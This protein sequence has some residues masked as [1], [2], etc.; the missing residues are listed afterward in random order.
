MA[1]ADKLYPNCDA[2]VWLRSCEQEVTE[3]LDGEITGELPEWLRGTLLRNG[4]GSLKVG[5]MR[6][7]HL[8]DSSA[9]LHRFAIHEGSVTYQ[10][11]FL[12]SSTYKRNQAAQRIVVS[13]FGTKAVPDPCH[14]IF[15]RVASVFKP[16]ETISDNAMISLYPFGDEIYAFT[17]GPVIHRI[18]PVTL[19][20]MERKNMMDS[21]ALVNHTS[22]PHVMSNGDVYNVGMSVVKGRVKHV[23]VKFPFTEK[24]DMFARARVVGSLR[25]RWPLHPAY[26]HTF[27]ITEKYFVIVEQPL[28]VSLYG[29]LRSQVAGAPLADSLHW[30]PDQDCLETRMNEDVSI[31]FSVQYQSI[32]S[33]R[34][35]LLNHRLVAHGVARA[36]DVYN[37]GMSVVK[38]RVKHVVV[39]FPFTEKGDMFARARVVGSL[40]PRWPL[41]P[42]YMHTFGITEKYFVIVEQPLAVSLYGALRSQVAGAPLADSLHWY[43]DQDTHIVLISRSTG[44]EER[45]Y[46]TEPLF[47]LHIINAFERDGTLVLDLCAYKDA[48]AIDAM[49]VQAIETHIV[50]ISRSTGKEERRYCTEPLFFLHIIN[51]FERDGTLVLDLCAYKDAKAIDAMYVQAIENMQSN[52]DYAEWF[53]GRPQRLELPLDA[54]TPARVAARPLAALGCETPRIHYDAFNGRPYRYFYAISS[55]VDAEYPG[56]VIKV[57]TW[58]GATLTWS[59]ADCYP[60]EPVFVPAPDAKSEDDGVLLSALVYG[61]DARRVAL[62][63]LCARSLRRRALA[64]F[65]T[66]SP[67]PKCLHGWFLRVK[68]NRPV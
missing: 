33:F 38:G 45:R 28:A 47:F 10:C 8:F 19:D 16:D 34:A 62:L 30:Y 26:M 13:E 22:H 65:R 5:D 27:G 2:S 32:P 60:S 57:D 6:F 25:P 56:A 17:E 3:P 64:A 66:P 59:S 1:A 61:R 35:R 49:Y 21:V 54:T 40:R 7:K 41:H 51:A 53:R 12:Q 48:K 23:V 52:A 4:P 67:A 43:P 29:A 15:D 58:T 20:T 42:A 44:K 68:S 39:K 63:V 46:C 37:V 36:S 55:D 11:R 24:G 18:D 50:L 31:R 9:L 14:T